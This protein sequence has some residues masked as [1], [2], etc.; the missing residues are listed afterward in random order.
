V[1]LTTANATLVAGSFDATFPSG[2]HISGSFSAP[3][4]APS[5]ASRGDS[6]C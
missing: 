6:G 5:T 2:D 3:A 4:C 1:T